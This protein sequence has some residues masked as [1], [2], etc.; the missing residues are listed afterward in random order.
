MTDAR[1][2]TPPPPA[3]HPNPGPSVTPPVSPPP[4]PPPRPRTTNGSSLLGCA[5]AISLVCNI[6]ALGCFLC[7][8]VILMLFYGGAESGSVTLAEHHYAG[9]S[10]SKNKIAIVRLEGVI[11]EGFL[12]YAHKQIDTAAA[13]KEVKAIVLR[14]NSPG[15]SI[16]ASDELYR[17]L[18]KLRD[19]DPKKKTNPKPLV[20]SMGSIAASG[21]YYVAMPAKTLVA[22]PTTLTGSIGVFASFPNIKGFT[23]EHKIY[24]ITIKQGEIKDSGSPFAEMTGKERQVWQDM[25]D[26]AYD[27]F[28]AVVEQGR[29]ELKKAKLLESFEVQPI[30]AGPPKPPLEQAHKYTRYRADGGIYTAD[31]ALNLKLIDQ[32]GTLEDAIQVAHDTAQLGEHYQVIEYERPKNLRELLFGVWSPGPERGFQTNPSLGLLDPG[33]LKNGLAP[34]LWYLAP[35]YELSGYLAAAE[36]P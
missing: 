9:E 4:P 20:V 31:V 28:L 22:E 21:G 2:P 29:P 3:A 6:V 32:I 7:L 24:M 5:F 18:L 30:N 26:H 33:R 8:C 23:D 17:R 14:I 11:L 13:D 27:Q 35:G 25:V 12:N 10:S 36:Q 15:G 1:E 19:G 16:T 34:R